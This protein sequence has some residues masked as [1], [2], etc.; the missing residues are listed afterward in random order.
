MSIAKRATL[1]YFGRKPIQYATGFLRPT[2]LTKTP[3]LKL[4][5]LISLRLAAELRV[6]KRVDSIVYAAQSTRF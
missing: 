4:V 6:D 5:K 2:R 3:T 1:G